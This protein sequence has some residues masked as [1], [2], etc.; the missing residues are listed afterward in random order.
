MYSIAK[1]QV[2]GF[3]DT[4]EVQTVFVEVDIQG[5]QSHLICVD[6]FCMMARSKPLTSQ[7]TRLL[8]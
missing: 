3:P 7:E 5:E 6:F 2:E 1:N 8:P 4:N